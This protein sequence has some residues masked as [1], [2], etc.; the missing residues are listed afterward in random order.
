MCLCIYQLLRKTDGESEHKTSSSVDSGRKS[1]NTHTASGSSV[2]N[3]DS[4]ARW[5]SVK[6][7]VDMCVYV[8]LSVSVCV[9]VSLSVCVCVCLS[10]CVY[11]YISEWQQR[12]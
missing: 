9:C 5:R 11:V 3:T 10:V 8:S 4:Q 1:S 12:S 7:V 2:A 6:M